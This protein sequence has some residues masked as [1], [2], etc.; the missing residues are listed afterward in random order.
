M[1]SRL[2][3]AHRLAKA[4]PFVAM[5][6][7]GLALLSPACNQAEPAPAR[8][9][10]LFIMIDTL[11][12]DHLSCYGYDRETSPNIDRFAAENIIFHNHY[13]SIPF[14]PGSHWSNFTGRHPHNFGDSISRAAEGVM[15]D[16]PVLTL[17]LREQGYRTAAFVSNDMVKFLGGN[18]GHFERFNERQYR[19]EHDTGFYQTTNAALEW[20]DGKA[21]KPFFLFI[22]YWDPHAEYN[23]IADFD[24]WSAGLEGNERQAALYDGEIRFV[25]CK[26]QMLLDKLDELDLQDSTIVVITADH[27]EAFG[28]HD[29]RDFLLEE[30]STFC[31]GHYKTLFDT[32]TRVPLMLRVP[33]VVGNREVESV[34]QSVDLLPTLLELLAMSNERSVDGRSLRPLIDGRQRPDGFAFSELRKRVKGRTVLSRSIVADGW[35]LMAI[36]SDQGEVHRLHRL[37]QGE[38]QDLADREGPVA[39]KLLQQIRELTGGKVMEEEKPDEETIELLRSLGYIEE[40]SK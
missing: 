36:E 13:C 27:G 26:V 4:L 32:E 12:A 30:Q 10:L 31:T 22:H 8:P 23:P 14:T 3:T 24:L 16:T 37:E 18:F 17:L 5:L 29:G 15:T 2:V 1:L 33:G 38:D 6:L 20:L 28:E 11:R 40:D 7:C 34:T 25:D 9:N 35:K 39:E 21:S 19:N